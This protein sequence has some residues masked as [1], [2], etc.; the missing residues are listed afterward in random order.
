M[1]VQSAYEMAFETPG[2]V[3]RARSDPVT[4]RDLIRHLDDDEVERI[5]SPCR[6]GAA[7]WSPRMG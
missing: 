1:L 3:T 6:S 4:L 5:G 2:E 7:G